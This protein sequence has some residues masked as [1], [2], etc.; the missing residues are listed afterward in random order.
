M[1]KPRTNGVAIVMLAVTLSSVAVLALLLII[2]GNGSSFDELKLLVGLVSLGWCGLAGHRLWLIYKRSRSAGQRKSTSASSKRT[3]LS[4]LPRD[5]LKKMIEDL[6]SPLESQRRI[7]IQAFVDLGTSPIPSFQC[8]P[9]RKY[10]QLQLVAAEVLIRDW[11]E[12]HQNDPDTT[13][14]DI[15]DE[16]F[17]FE[18]ECSDGRRFR[19]RRLAKR[20]SPSAPPQT[21]KPSVLNRT[22]DRLSD[23]VKDSILD[24]S[25]GPE[26]NE[27]SAP[28]SEDIALQPLD[29]KAFE[30]RMK[31]RVGDALEVTA[32]ILSKPATDRELAECAEQLGKVADSFR[33]NALEVAMELRTTVARPE[34]DTKNTHSEMA[35]KSWAKKFRLMRASG[36]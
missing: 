34:S 24:F 14:A 8:W 33:W 2:P 27:F 23:I 10:T 31:P 11:L 26:P 21:V 6:N 5:R 36:F 15:I 32:E 35:P 13:S 22:L 3:Q 17:P 12:I 18:D 16:L 9:E 1:C 4:E 20:Q 28:N 25:I 29:R 7:A 30:E 19:L